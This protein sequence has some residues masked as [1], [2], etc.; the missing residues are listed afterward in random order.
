ME[1]EHKDAADEPSVEK[2]HPKRNTE[3][4]K[5]R[6]PNTRSREEIRETTIPRKND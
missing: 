6:A 4:D 2:K 5:E 1:R 3:D